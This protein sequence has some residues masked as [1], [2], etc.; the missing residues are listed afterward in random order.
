ME[1][2]IEFIRNLVRRSLKELG[3]A[4]AGPTSETLLTLSGYYVGREFRFADVRAVWMASEG[5]IKV[6][7]D[8]GEV[9]QVVD[10]GEHRHMKAA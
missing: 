5:R 3:L 1:P 7:D 9:L 4:D 10:L 2:S 6:Y 8:D